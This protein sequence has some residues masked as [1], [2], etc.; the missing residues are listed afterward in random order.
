MICDKFFMTLQNFH[1]DYFQRCSFYILSFAKGCDIM[2]L[3]LKKAFFPMK[4]IWITTTLS[5][6]CTFKS[7]SASIAAGILKLHPLIYF[8]NG[9][10]MESNFSAL[11]KCC[12]RLV[13][14]VT[15]S[16]TWYFYE[17]LIWWYLTFVRFHHTLSYIF[18]TFFLFF[19]W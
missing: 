7:I 17:N 1:V 5:F 2:F 9:K 18:Y 15:S 14:I 13:P 10:W 16:D 6:S 12:T 8:G 3:M 19:T 4:F 11:R